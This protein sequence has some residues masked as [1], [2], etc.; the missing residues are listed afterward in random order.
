MLWILVRTGIMEDSVLTLY[1]SDTYF[2]VSID[3][4]LDTYFTVSIHY[5]SD[6]YFPMSQKQSLFFF[7]FFPKD[8]NSGCLQMVNI[9]F[10]QQYLRKKE[11]GVYVKFFCNLQPNTPGVFHTDTRPNLAW[12]NGKLLG[13]PVNEAIYCSKNITASKIFNI[14]NFVCHEGHVC[15]HAV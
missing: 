7:Y 1:L 10:G 2:P 5:H 4:H 13:K 9:G 3:I 8:R 6:L 14:F 11:C 15:K 12:R